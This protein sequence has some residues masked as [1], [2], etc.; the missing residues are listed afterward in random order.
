MVKKYTRGTKMDKQ[1]YL[2]LVKHVTISN[3]SKDLLLSLTPS[4]YIGLAETITSL[5]L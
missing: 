1:D 3:K 2:D 5:K 4:N